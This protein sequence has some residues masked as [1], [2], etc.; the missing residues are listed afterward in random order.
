MEH[1]LFLAHVTMF[2]PSLQAHMVKIYRNMNALT[3]H[4]YCEG[5]TNTIRLR[6]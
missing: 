4:V 2:L 6:R 3:L 1:F 5:K